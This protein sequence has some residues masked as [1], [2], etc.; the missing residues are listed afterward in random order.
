MS[1]ITYAEH[2]N[3]HSFFQQ[4]R[5][6][7]EASREEVAY[8]WQFCVADEGEADKVKEIIE[9]CELSE[10]DAQRLGQGIKNYYQDSLE[11]SSVKDSLPAHLDFLKQACD[12]SAD[13]T[14]MRN[15]LDY[16]VK[17]LSK[18][19]GEQPTQAPGMTAAGG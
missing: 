2:T 1:S 8:L 18:I 13:N 6:L 5:T 14:W 10:I 4:A 16:L 11:L 3:G 7:R 15:T 12:W 9:S 17:N 19:L